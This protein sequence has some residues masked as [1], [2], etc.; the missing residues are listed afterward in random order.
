MNDVW[1]QIVG[2]DL[3]GIVFVRDYLQLQFNPPPT[4]NAY[5]PTTISTK[6]KTARFGETDFPNLI[7]GQIGKVVS[8]VTIKE[9]D[10]FQIIFADDSEISISLK[11]EDYR[12]PEAV[13]FFGKNK[14]LVV[15]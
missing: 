11:E 13:N 12:S 8:K 7:I 9:K 6:G 1:N 3:S 5:T 2:E 10:S 15:F 14:E 4:I